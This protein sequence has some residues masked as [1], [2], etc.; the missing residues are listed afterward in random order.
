MEYAKHLESKVQ[1]IMK[2]ISRNYELYIFQKG[3]QLSDQYVQNPVGSP[4][5]TDDSVKMKGN[6]WWEYATKEPNILVTA[7]ISF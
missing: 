5:V 2:L 4:R 3:H 7:G 6:I 1:K